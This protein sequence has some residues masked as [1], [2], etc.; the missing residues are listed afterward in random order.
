MANDWSDVL[1]GVFM[2]VLFAGTA[3]ASLL[4]LFV[5]SL[6]LTGLCR[7][8]GIGLSLSTIASMVAYCQLPLALRNAVYAGY[9]LAT[10][11]LLP[12]LHLNSL[13]PVTSGMVHTTLQHF[14]LFVLWSYVLLGV[15][16]AVASGGRQGRAWAVLALFVVTN[17]LLNFLF[18][19][20]PTG[21]RL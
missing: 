21:G 3:L 4:S 15:G 16:L 6:L 7:V 5:N 14:D 1:Y 10:H 18:S 17:G 20:F 9:D 2:V 8:V 13:I 12:S 19:Y 11:S